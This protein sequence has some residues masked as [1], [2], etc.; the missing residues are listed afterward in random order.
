M[1]SEGIVST[2]DGLLERAKAQDPAAWQR[3]RD[4]YAPL[5]Y[6]WCRRANVPVEDS[7]DIGQEVFLAVARGLNTFRRNQPG[8]SFR[9]W[10]RSI[11][12]SKIVDWLRRTRTWNIN[13]T[14]GDL[15]TNEAAPDWLDAPSADENIEE[16]GLLYRQAVQIIS[17]DFPAWYAEAFFRLVLDEATPRD[18]AA[19][20]GLRT[21][22]VYNAKARVLRRL[23][24]EFAD[25]VQ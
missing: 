22:A 15:A 9:A 23:R 3:L 24:E 19:D 25:L 5:V 7:G 12:R 16:E 4:L 20:L 18:V 13:G 10:L 14:G 21:S 11:T 8:H 6:R 1:M 17:R 2:S